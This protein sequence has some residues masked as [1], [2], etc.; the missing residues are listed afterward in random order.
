MSMRKASLVGVIVVA[1]VVAAVAHDNHGSSGGDAF[2]PNAPRQPSPVTAAAIALKTIEVDFGT[3]EETVRLSGVVRASP[4]RRFAV[5]AP[6]EG[7][8]AFLDGADPAAVW[9]QTGD[10]V[11]RGDTVAV[12]HSPRLAQLVH[13]QLKTEVEYEHARSEVATS[14][15]SIQTLSKQVESAERQAAL[16]EQEVARLKAGTDA[17]GANMRAQRE[18]AAI[19]AR[20][21]VDALAAARDQQVRELESMQRR[22]EASGRAAAALRNVIAMV[23]NGPMG[24]GDAP[25]PGAGE[26]PVGVIKLRSPI[27]GMIVRRGSRGGG[28]EDRIPAIGQR[29]A[30]GDL[31]LEVVDY[32]QVQIEGELPES[33]AVALAS[34]LAEHGP[35]ESEHEVRVRS[36]I[37]GE[38]IVSGRIRSLSPVVD[39]IKRTSHLIIDAAN[40]AGILRDGMYVD[41]SAVL[42]RN[43]SAIVVP[44]SAIVSDGPLRFVFVKHKD[45]YVKRDVRLG[46]SDDRV[47]EVLEGIV[48][49]D[50]VVVSGAY[51]LSQLRPVGAAVP[52]DDHGHN[53]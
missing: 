5:S 46:A 15:A 53:H 45:T 32:S 4:E 16:A 25:W 8:L 22:A 12:L 1:V 43:K 51:S 42:R 20:T 28:A 11:K 3:I 40:D 50:E 36:T 6:V 14:R 31:L 23:V 49:G 52:M 33:L 37:G 35:A 26:D 13:E 17:V 47:V 2:D 29:V 48:P 27:D 30:E 18:A 9:L 39:P 41:L 34:S 38:V 10:L 44:L 24:S 19:Q 21:Q 7:M